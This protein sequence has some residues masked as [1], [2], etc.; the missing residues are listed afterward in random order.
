MA[1][2]RS[3]NFATLCYDESSHFDDLISALDTLHISYLISPLHD[4]D[5]DQFHVLKKGHWHIILVFDSLK[6][7]A[8]VKDLLF[9]ASK[10][11]VVSFV[12]CEI[13]NSLVSY[14]RYLCHLDDSDK[15]RYD[16]NAVIQHGMDY[17]SLI[18]AKSD[19]FSS[20]IN[21][22]DYVYCNHVTSFSE[23][24]MYARFHDADMLHTILHESFTVR[25][26]IRSFAQ[27]HSFDTS[28]QKEDE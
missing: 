12:G 4:A 2:L 20:F 16:T 14:A 22:V 26:F 19:Y 21:L 8:Q 5:F 10:P 9:E 1:T 27:T 24:V 23:L 17:V 7:V 25:E 28:S 18:S 11:F 15:A 13:V 3:K 6:S